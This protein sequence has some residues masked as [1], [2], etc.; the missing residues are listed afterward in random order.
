[1]LI[2][3]APAQRPKVLILDDE[4][5]IANNLA[6]MLTHFGYDA[7][8][9]YSGHTA[10]DLAMDWIPDLLVSDIFVPDMNGVEAASKVLALNPQCKLLFLTGDLPA[11][12]WVQRYRAQGLPARTLLKPVSPADLF[13]SV[14]QALPPMVASY[15][16]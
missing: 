15:D 14:A 7:I 3:P 11:V 2:P 12:D 1:M 9:V 6:T 16:A 10:I 4:A 8:P 5:N 13:E